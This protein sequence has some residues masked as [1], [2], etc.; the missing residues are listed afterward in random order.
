M[1]FL[2]PSMITNV[3]D[4]RETTHRVASGTSTAYVAFVVRRHELRTTLQRLELRGP[5][6]TNRS[7]IE[8]LLAAV[9]IAGLGAL[10]TS[11]L[12]VSTGHAAVVFG[13]AAISLA[14]A[15]HGLWR[16]KSAEH[17]RQI[18][19]LRGEL[20]Q[21]AEHCGACAYPIGELRIESDGCVVCPECG[22][23]WEAQATPPET[24][25]GHDA[26]GKPLKLVRFNVR[27][28]IARH[29][30]WL[31][32]Q[33]A[34][35][36]S[37]LRRELRDMTVVFPLALGIAGLVIATLIRQPPIARGWIAAGFL[38]LGVAAIPLVRWN[39]RRK[40]RRRISRLQAALRPLDP[41]CLAC[42]HELAECALEGDGCRVCLECGAAWRLGDRA[43]EAASATSVR[44]DDF[45][46]T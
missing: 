25:E 36:A 19:Y 15:V 42:G 24:P 33:L 44:N 10:A 27:L 4:D 45:T 5:P 31:R 8:Y 7:V 38:V 28:Q 35:G 11:L 41:I 14:I 21:F 29:Q 6:S 43:T 22:A 20:R 32:E 9:L 2:P 37:Q 13:L 39:T 18:G 30:A 3:V 12:A 17:A 26:R 34:E 16:D 46:S 1:A 23:A 40:H